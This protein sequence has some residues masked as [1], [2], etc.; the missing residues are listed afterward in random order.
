MCSSSFENFE[1]LC[2]LVD[3]K[4]TQPLYRVNHASELNSA[5]RSTSDML[6]SNLII[7][8][9]Y[10]KSAKVKKVVQFPLAF[11]QSAQL[12]IFQLI[13][14]KN[15]YMTSEYLYS[16]QKWFFIMDE[17]EAVNEWFSEALAE[18]TYKLIENKKL[19]LEEVKLILQNCQ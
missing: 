1:K 5:L 3:M 11:T 10:D 6:A 15:L 19:P 18:M 17:F 14:R 2:K 12:E 7:L 4:Y 16:L 8:R 13:C 9:K